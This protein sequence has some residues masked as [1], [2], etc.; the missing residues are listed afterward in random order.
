MNF[1]MYFIKGTH[2]VFQGLSVESTVSDNIQ[3]IIN[4]PE[5][6]AHP[7]RKTGTGDR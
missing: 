6:R 4:T 2:K 5:A 3:V 7:P 1:S